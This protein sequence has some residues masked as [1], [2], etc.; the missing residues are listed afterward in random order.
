M[1]STSPCSERE[2]PSV[3]LVLGSITALGAFLRFWGMGD[4]GLH[5][6]E[7]TMGLAVRGILDSGS[8]LLPSGMYYARGLALTYL[9]AASAQ[10]FGLTEWA[11]R[12]PSAIAGTVMIAASYFLGKRFLPANGSL[13]FALIIALLP[14]MISVSQTARMYVFY[15]TFIII[16]ATAIFRWER[17]E[18]MLDYAL[19]FIPFLIALHFHSLSIF[20]SLLFLFPGIL[21]MSWRIFALGGFA[22][23]ACF[24]A[25]K[26]ATT[27]LRLHYFGTIDFSLNNGIA[28]GNRIDTSGLADISVA[29]YVLTG[30]FFCFAIIIW[31]LAAR[32]LSAGSHKIEKVGALSAWVIAIIGAAAM[33][34]H[35]AAIFFAVGTVV[36]LRCGGRWL[37][38]LCLAGVIFLFASTQVIGLWQSGDFDRPRDILMTMLGAPNPW[39][40]LRF[41]TYFPIAIVAYVFVFSYFA[42]SFIRGRAVPDHIL[43]VLIGVNALGDVRVTLE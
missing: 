31:F 39:P 42:I 9:M 8:P 28:D 10:V 32:D 16:F 15:L 17:S 3:W 18:S 27:W 43:L 33:H 41:A 21:K 38:P 6:D 5:G 37:W 40:Y 22:L 34:Y 1:F 11:L 24:A 20:A 19:A 30:I 7:E 26:L 35:I 25:F 4:I 14:A 2:S 36:F 23:V 12:F 29:S 13:V